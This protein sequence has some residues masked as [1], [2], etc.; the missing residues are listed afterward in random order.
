MHITSHACMPFSDRDMSWQMRNQSASTHQ[1]LHL[2]VQS[3]M[4]RAVAALGRDEVTDILEQ[5]GKIEVNCNFCNETFEFGQ[6]DVES[7][8]LAAADPS[9]GDGGGASNAGSDSEEGPQFKAVPGLIREDAVVDG[10]MQVCRP[11]L[12]CVSHR[13]RDS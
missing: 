11:V 9:A 10:A 6:A 13:S 12:A 4:K 3:R 5:E 2:G 7:A 8:L 1:W